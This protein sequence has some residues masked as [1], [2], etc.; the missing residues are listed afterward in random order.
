MDCLCRGDHWSPVGFTKI[1]GKKPMISYVQNRY[2]I[3]GLTIIWAGDLFLINADSMVIVHLKFELNN[4]QF[5]ITGKFPRFLWKIK[6]PK[7]IFDKYLK[8]Y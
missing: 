3:Y 6:N 1:S 2:R 4:L 5:L 7:K 8:N